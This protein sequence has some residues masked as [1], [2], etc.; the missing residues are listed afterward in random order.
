MNEL[1]VEKYRPSTLD[2]YVFMNDEQRSQIEYWVNNKNVPNLL[3]SGVQGTG[4][5]TLIKI[6]INAL[7]IHDYD[8]LQINASRERGIDIARE[9][10][11]NFSQTMPYGDLKV[12]FLDEVDY[13]TP[14]FQAALR[15]AIEEYSQT[16]RFFMTCNYPHKII[17]ALHS[18]CQGFHI[19]KLNK[20]EF[21]IRIATILSDENIDI[22]LE[23]LDMFVEATYPD[24]RKCINLCQQ[25]STTGTLV[26]PSTKSST[27]D[28][29]LV[30][31]DLIKK[32][33]IREG[34]Q[35][36]CSQARPE[37]MD[38]IFRWCYENLDLWSATE[39]GQDEAIL[40]IRKALV[41]HATCADAEIN[42]A[43]MFVE[44]SQI[45]QN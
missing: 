28:F 24:L 1:W 11:K 29:K 2:G 14:D 43:A 31:V 3:I 25:N 12:V 21:T 17:P 6:L 45:N 7:E 15:G 18:R 33:K 39:D 37:E 23:T 22:E 20:D 9:K 10:I 41:N 42:L 36:I 32:G 35:L 4:K 16:V 8:L 13:A 34:R 19:D 44:L 26:L 40:I 5:T 30:L 38:D 27:V